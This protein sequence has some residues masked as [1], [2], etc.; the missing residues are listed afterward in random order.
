MTP[1]KIFTLASSR[2][3]PMPLAPRWGKVTSSRSKCGFTFMNS[4]QT[5]RIPLS[6]KD[7]PMPL[8]LQS[9]LHSVYD[10]AVYGKY[11]YQESPQPPLPPDDARWAEQCLVRKG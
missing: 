4:R 10:A 9:L 7:A 5:M 11:I 1:G 6:E 3:P 8:D 2:T